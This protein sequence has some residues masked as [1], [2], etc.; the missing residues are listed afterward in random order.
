MIRRPQ[1]R[2]DRLKQLRDQ[3]AS[4]VFSRWW[5]HEGDE[6]YFVVLPHLRVGTAAVLRARGRVDFRWFESPRYLGKTEVA[7]SALTRAAAGLQGT[8]LV[9]QYI[10][11]LL[12][13]ECAKVRG[14]AAGAV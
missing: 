1:Q 13:D 12:R 14:V 3:I 8:P 7:A 11:Q 9:S 5:N 2:L 6:N 10:T 4:K